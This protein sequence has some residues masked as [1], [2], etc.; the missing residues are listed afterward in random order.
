MLSRSHK[1]ASF[2]KF[3]SCI[4]SRKS[5]FSC[6]KIRKAS[7]NPSF[8]SVNALSFFLC[9][10]T[11]SAH[12]DSSLFKAFKIADILISATCCIP[13]QVSILYPFILPSLKSRS[14]IFFNLPV[15]VF[16]PFFAFL[17]YFNEIQ[18]S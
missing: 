7:R 5:K 13:L 2:N 10:A 1:L 3:L 16:S 6:N 15:Q 14:L 17:L 11:I 12:S 18:L 9:S 8:S 4:V